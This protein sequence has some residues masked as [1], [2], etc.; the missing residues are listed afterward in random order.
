MSRKWVDDRLEKQVTDEETLFD[1]EKEGYQPELFHVDKKCKKTRKKL[2]QL[3]QKKVRVPR[4][5]I[6]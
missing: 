5:A 6:K 4:T 1:M 3:Y 2:K